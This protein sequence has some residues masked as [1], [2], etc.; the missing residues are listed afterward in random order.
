MS[1]TTTS[2][3]LSR[4]AALGAAAAL[5]AS[6][7]VTS[8]TPTPAAAADASLPT[9]VSAD[10]LPTVQIDGVVWDQLVIGGT[11]YVAGS[12]TSARP[13]GAA[14]GTDETPR[15]NVLAYTLATGELVTGFAPSFN[16]QVKDLVA[17]ADG[18]TLYAGGSFTAVN[19]VARSRL[20]AI[21]LTTGALKSWAPAANATVQG[22]AVSGSIVYVGGTFTTIN[23]QARARLAAVDGSTGVL[24]PFTAAVDDNQ[25]NAIQVAPD[26]QSIVIAGNFT[27]VAGSSSP[28][29]GLARLDAAT[30]TSLAL[31]VNTEVRDAGPNSAI[32]SLSSNGTYFYGTG[33]AYG[34]GGNSEGTFAASWATGELVWLEDCHG[35]TY[36]AAAD[37]DVVYL[38][39]HKH[40]CGNSGGFPQTTPWTYQH[41]TAVTNDVRGVNTADIYGYPDHPGTPR[42]QFLEWY[43]KFTP[44]NFTGA[45]QG[46]WNVVVS[47]DYVLYAGEFLGVNNTAQ[48]GLV[49][50]AKRT[51]APNKMGPRNSGPYFTLTAASFR[52]GQV[53]L[54]WPGNPD[55]DGDTV[56]YSLYRQTLSSQ[57]VYSKTVSAPFW[58]HS[59]MT[60]TDSSLTPGSSQRYK[61]VAT[62]ADG[63]Q[64]QSDWVTVTVNDAALSSYASGV[65]ADSPTSYWRL[66]DTSGATTAV[67]W[68]GAQDLTLGTGVSLG[69]VGAVNGDAGTAATFS[70]TTTGIAGTTTAVAG[71][72]TFS[73]E[74]WFKTT[75]T[76]GGKIVGFGDSAS[77]VSSSYDRHVYMTNTGQVV[78]GVYPG[79]VRTVS[80]SSA[81]N[82]GQWHHVVAS[83]GDAGMQLYVDGRRVGQRTDTTTAQAYSG[84]WRVGGDNLSGWTSAPTSQYLAGS[85]DEV[86][87][88]P[89]V[90][91]ADRIRAHYTASGRTPN[92]PAPPTDGYGAAVYAADPDLYWRLDE[93]SGSS[94]S[95]SGM[96]SNGGAMT[97]SWS[98]QA[99]GALVGVSSNRSVRF[100]GN[101]NIYS[102]A[103]FV[104]P[105]IY[106]LEA[107]FR[108]SSTSGGKIIGLG[109]S[110]TGGSSNYDRHVYMQ[111][112]G[113]LV[114]GTYTGVMNTITTAA[115]FND[116]AWHYVMAT[117][118]STGMVL[119][120]DGQNVGT[121]PQN[122]AQSYTGYWRVGGDTT[123]GSTSAYL[124]GYYDEVAVYSRALTA[125]DALVHYGLGATGVAPNLPPQAAIQA[126]VSGRLLTVNGS[127]SSDPD[128]TIAGYLWDFGDGSQSS[129]PAPQHT[130]AAVGTYTVK[131]TVTDDDGATAVT[132]QS[133]TVVNTD[134]SA[135]FEVANDFLAVTVDA[136]TS[137]DPDGSALSAA[138]DFGDGT[139]STGLLAS[140]TYA[141]NGTFTI[142]LRVTDPD[143]GSATT[144]RDVTVHANRSP[145]ASF[146]ATS[147]GLTS[148]F[149]ASA[150]V[151]PDGPIAAY[152]WNFPDGT[153]ASGPQV[154]HAFAAAGTYS[155]TLTVRDAQ[156]LTNTQTS[157]VTVTTNQVP[158]A[159]IQSTVFDQAVSVSASGSTDPDGSVVGYAW[160][161]GDGS[162]G[163]GVTVQHAY[164][165]PGSYA[166]TLTVTDDLGAT[167]TTTSTVIATAPV[168]YAQDT[169]VRQSTTGWGTA[170][171]GGAW[172]QYGSNSQYRV[173]NGVGVATIAAAGG[174]PRQ[175]LRGVSVLD[176][177]ELVQFSLDKIGTGGGTYVSL[178]NRAGSWASL[179]RAKVW[180][181]STGALVLSLTRQTTTEV[182]LAQTTLAATLTPG[183]VLNLRF[184]AE[185]S[186]PTTL[187]ARAWLQGTAEPTV[188]QVLATDST[189]ELQD[190]GAVG[191]DTSLS[192][193]ATNAPVAVSFDNLYTGRP[194]AALPVPNT[195][196]VAQFTA[197]VSDLTVNVDASS[198]SDPDGSIAGYAWSFD[199]VAA[200]GATAS[201]TFAAT[202]VYPVTLTVT[203]NR[204]GVSSSTQQVTVTAPVPNQSPV[205][206][207][208]PTVT[209]LTVSTDASA[210]SDPDGTVVAYGWSFGGVFA[211]GVTANYTFP[212]AGTYPVTLTVTDD[213][214][215]TTSVTQQV[216][217]SAAPPVETVIAEDLFARTQ[218]TGWGASTSGGNW[219]NYGSASQYSVSPGAGL[220]KLNTAGS[221]PRLQLQGVSAVDVDIVNTFSVDKVATGGGFYY[222]QT[223]R[224]SGWSSMY[225]A[226]IWVKSNGALN[227]SL[228]RIQGS[229]VTIA[230]ANLD[231]LVLTGGD[232]IKTRF[233]VTG[234]NPTSLQMRVWRDGTPEPTSWQLFGTDSTA[235]LQDA[236]GVGID[237]TLSGSATNAPLAVR[238][239]QFRVVVPQ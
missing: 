162:T 160:A 141:V 108:T 100:T 87:V 212:A 186:S 125:A 156:G 34:G 97:G 117:Q 43:P 81:Y 157:T 132:Q 187:R 207:F 26:G 200:S 154:S 229:E 165:T 155:V 145:V 65:L 219:T 153:T 70:G 53:R 32:G 45:E 129:D 206:A 124:R 77:G 16:A 217:V 232:V 86:A 123:W 199:G 46:P 150:S 109:S 143:G 236:G 27:S 179:Y 190:A 161:F 139:T 180:I 128:G 18:K 228:T 112:D 102:S 231:G 182:S 195:L 134:P 54:N 204:G 6:G 136:A 174:T 107:W 59:A 111:N 80:S 94:V 234:S 196:P 79:A 148:E 211:S 147:S 104:D 21:D 84:Y 35:D 72:S 218:A 88:Y 64:A 126:Q 158:V 135:A 38:A 71:P 118:S 198:S 131:L 66:N 51:I 101:G 178:T 90:L 225:R 48:Q 146:S 233:R 50:F 215:A 82:D 3:A 5:A 226:K 221:L 49:R 172:T 24:Q 22:L 11:V 110:Q 122:D 121:N 23:N 4:L 31:P 61:I 113:K 181:K 52:T 163:T 237:T 89:T 203:D 235:E 40:Y 73:V 106:T 8:V 168:V 142:T 202:G 193:S 130:Y 230:A 170:E 209:N 224:T 75:S 140:H 133:V 239:T 96:S 127:G 222:S 62:D 151:D 173:A 17:S 55:P 36:S 175:Q 13:A 37:G 57:P 227:L 205:A 47:G 33:W 78:F 188:W 169:F 149:D 67:D 14:A 177:D 167:A 44:G 83:L 220:L 223:A 95:D 91:S 93:T 164:A 19:G 183:A 92:V 42:P 98:R 85:I 103:S 208:T 191:V 60:F 58:Q 119:Y 56:V 201:H 68:A 1:H 176:T 76:T 197:S 105:S 2:S 115:S 12:F 15:A 28:G 39:S 120:V 185:G 116:N 189:A 63:N 159:R 171:T 7:L 41:G 194:G 29:Y 9:T 25:V 192:G 10:A 214:G 210:S 238:V 74:A 166:V 99:G 69:A 20:A 216:T 144:S 137:V 114:F 30:G 138:W 213:D 152:E 184:Q